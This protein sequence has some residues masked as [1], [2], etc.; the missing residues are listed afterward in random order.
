[1]LPNVR[2]AELI[3]NVYGLAV[4]T[5]TLMA[6]TAETCAALQE[7]ADVIACQLKAA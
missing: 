5:G 6:W 1:M 3:H 4:S 7:T 2:V